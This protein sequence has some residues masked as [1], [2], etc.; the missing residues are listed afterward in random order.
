MKH[1]YVEAKPLSGSTKKLAIL[2]HGVGSNAEDLAMI[3]PYMQ[4]SLPD[5]SFI[6]LNGPQKYDLA[7]FGY[8]WFSFQSR[9]LEDLERE[10][11]KTL[12][13]V[14]D[15]IEEKLQELSLGFEDLFLIGFSQGAMLATH[16]ATSFNKKLGGIIA[17]AGTIIP[18]SSFEGN[19]KTPICFIYGTEDEIL[20]L[21]RLRNS[22]E[23][24]KQIGFNVESN[25][26]ADLGH[27]IDLKSIAFANNFILKLL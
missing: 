9:E 19:T 18:R 7:A 15:F 5:F 26:I 11:G 22:T 17:F 21:E 4:E 13:A 14:L 20:S 12:P 27:S 3:I 8:Q 24:L 1:G 23:M 2:L 6:S 10:V 16:I 25:E